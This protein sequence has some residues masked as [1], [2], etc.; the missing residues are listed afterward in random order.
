MRTR[1]SPTASPGRLGRVPG[2]PCAVALAA[3]LWACGPADPVDRY[4][5][6]EEALKRG[7]AIFVGT[8]TGYCHVEGASNGDIPNLFDGEW[9]HGGSNAE[10]FRT[11]AQGVPGT[12][13]VAWASALPEGEDD[14]WKVIAFLRSRGSP[15]R[16]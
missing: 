11:I 7:E 5:T 3:L 13:M 14:I 15:G 6:D 9:K 1:G 12:Q 10:I 16:P 2:S 4:L 8:C